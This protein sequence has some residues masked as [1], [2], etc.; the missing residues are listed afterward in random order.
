MDMFQYPTISDLADHLDKHELPTKV[1][2]KA[3]EIAAR[4]REALASKN[5]AAAFKRLRTNRSEG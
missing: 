1:E 3:V 4:Q 2:N 5:L